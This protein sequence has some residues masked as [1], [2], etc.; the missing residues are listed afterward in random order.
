L[1]IREAALIC[2][3]AVICCV[4]L[5]K[6]RIGL[7]GFVWFALLRPDE[8]AWVEGKYPF[9]TAL[10]VA[11]LAGGLRYVGR[12]PLLFQN[13]ITRQ[14]LLLQIPLGLSVVFC[15][16]TFL[17]PDRYSEYSRMILILLL[18]PLALEAHAHVREMLLVMAFSLGALG[19]KFG[20]YGLAH[21]GVG[22][23][24][25]LGN[26]YDNNTLGLAAAMAVPLCHQSMT[27]ISS[28]WAKAVLLGM[29]CTATATV[30]MSNSRGASLSLGVGFL[31]ILL[32]SKHKLLTI[33]AI[34]L[35]SFPAIYMVQD[36]YFERMSTIADYKSEAS[37]ASRIEFAGAAI[38]TWEAYPLF[39][40][41]FGS[42]N[43][44]ALN[45]R[46]LGRDDF[47]AAHNTY[48]QMLADSGG[49]AYILY[50]GLLFGTL[51]WLYKRARLT[52]ESD[53]LG[54]DDLGAN[55]ARAIAA[56][57]LVFAVGGIFG[58]MQRYDFPYMLMM[59]AAAL[60]AVERNGVEEQTEGSEA[61]E[62]VPTLE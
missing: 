29:I 35:A 24:E 26:Q 8:L 21:G 1:S 60:H 3:I 27:M 22:F 20:L 17:S 28:K 57:L 16:G 41:G 15:E 51:L 47:H 9:S 2:I 58:S 37:A 44:A 62:M 38:R 54:S 55:I 50:V 5:V 40:V 14:L 34:A 11:V 49:F 4:S 6:P 19:V 45:R 61:L 13:P 23:A 18:I 52:T 39:G 56:P 30:V 31:V 59:C 48:L 33:C 43:Y 42:R 12:I 36:Q 7:Y 53:D 25:G 10:A 46:F 32:R